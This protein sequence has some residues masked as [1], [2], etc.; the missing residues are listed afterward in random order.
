MPKLLHIQKQETVY[1]MKRL[2]ENGNLSD[3]HQNLVV[4]QKMLVLFALIAWYACIFGVYG[5]IG[6]KKKEREVNGVILAQFKPRLL[7]QRRDVC[8]GSLEAPPIL[9]LD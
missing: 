8:P 7:G 9:L 4:M 5:N 2:S 1:W 3:S 6:Q